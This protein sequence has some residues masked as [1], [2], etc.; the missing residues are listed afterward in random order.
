MDKAIKM[1]KP[2]TQSDTILRRDSNGIPYFEK[3]T[4]VQEFDGLAFHEVPEQR[5]V[6]KIPID[7][8]S[9]YFKSIDT[10]IILIRKRYNSDFQEQIGYF[11]QA[12]ELRVPIER[13]FAL[14]WFKRVRSGKIMC[15][16]Y[17]DGLGFVTQPL[18]INDP[19][20]VTKR[21]KAIRVTQSE[22][23]DLLIKHDALGVFDEIK[24]AEDP[25]KTE[26][27]LNV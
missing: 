4:T 22:A 5:K 24:S 16:N 3:V 27:R 15:C 10:S 7:E 26:Y 21:G 19:D 20:F 25:S 23:R 13:A 8:K 14:T 2:I 12:I 9:G 6:E 11:R 17:T 1:V 18:A